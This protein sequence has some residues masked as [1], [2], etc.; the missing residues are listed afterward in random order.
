MVTFSNTLLS[1]LSEF[2]HPALPISAE[3]GDPYLYLGEVA[4][5][6]RERNP[7]RAA[8]VL[9]ERLDGA[10]TARAAAILGGLSM[11]QEQ[12]RSHAPT[13]RAALADRRPEIVAAAVEAL[14]TVG[15][16]SCSAQIAQLAADPDPTVRAAALR[17]MAAERHPDA[18]RVLRGAL[19]DC[20]L[21]VRANAV[22][23]LVELVGLE[24]EPWV[25][26]LAHDPARLVRETVADA[27]EFERENPRDDL[28]EPG[29]VGE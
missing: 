3:L 25:S 20:D 5:G 7:E 28:P 1:L 24:A 22:E 18:V 13:F 2:D 27:L 29:A 23:S 9:L 4:G 15:D 19:G 6:L 14:S 16:T 21:Y 17:F 10:D 11:R 8:R 26:P 12:D